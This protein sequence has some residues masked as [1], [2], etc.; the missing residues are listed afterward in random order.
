MDGLLIVFWLSLSSE[1]VCQENMQLFATI[2]EKS[3]EAYI[4]ANMIIAMGD[5]A[6]A[7]PNIVEP[8]TQ[9]I[10]QRLV[11]FFFLLKKKYQY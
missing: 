7:Y 8:W 2:A 4:R 9:Q 3:P 10:F 6:T 5:L 1:Q 11:A